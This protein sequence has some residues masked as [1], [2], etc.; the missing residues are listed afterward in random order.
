MMYIKGCFVCIMAKDK[1]QN[2]YIIKV[3]THNWKF[4]HIKAMVCCNSVCVAMSEEGN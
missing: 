3:Q 4:M 2:I 1:M